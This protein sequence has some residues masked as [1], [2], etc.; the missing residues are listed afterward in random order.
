MNILLWVLQ[1]L[2]ALLYLAG[3]AYKAFSFEQVAKELTTLP[4]AGWRVLGVVELVGGVLLILPAA[5]GWMPTLTPLAA[6]VLTVETVALAGIYA[7]HS[8]KLTA[9]NPLVWSLVMA[10]L[11][12]FVTFGRYVLSPVA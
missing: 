7:R 6:A 2:L 3:G 11:V 4:H 12:A 5:L 9:E 1:G 8:R 10:A